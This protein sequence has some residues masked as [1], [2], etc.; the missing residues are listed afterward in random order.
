ASGGLASSSLWLVGRADLLGQL[1]PL[2]AVSDLSPQPPLERLRAGFDD[3][4]QLLHARAHQVTVDLDLVEGRQELLD[5]QLQGAVKAPVVGGEVRDVR[6]I[7][8]VIVARGD[9]VVEEQ[10]DRVHQILAVDLVDLKLAQQQ[11]GRAAARTVEVQSVAEV[12]DVRHLEDVDEDVDLAAVRGV[13]EVKAPV[14][15]HQVEAL[16]GLIAQRRKN[17]QHRFAVTLGD[18]V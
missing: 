7:D 6:R 16:V 18:R 2:K 3:S 1:V 11:V 9:A 8:G 5:V 4:P 17:G 10:G 13:V 14:P 15:V 12:D